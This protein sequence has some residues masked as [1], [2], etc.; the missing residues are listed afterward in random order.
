[1]RINLEAFLG[2]IGSLE[3]L[4]DMSRE[5]PSYFQKCVCLCGNNMVTME[6]EIKALYSQITEAADMLPKG[7]MTKTLQFR[8][9]EYGKSIELLSAVSSQLRSSGGYVWV[10]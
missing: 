3:E 8:L 4:L 1:M 10:N 7:V 9:G 6:G 5:D 2:M